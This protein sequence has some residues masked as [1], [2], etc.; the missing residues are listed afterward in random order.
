MLK[1]VESSGS[2]EEAEASLTVTSN[3]SRFDP[4]VCPLVLMLVF[5]AGCLAGKDL[6]QSTQH[7]VVEGGKTK[8]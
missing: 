3:G 2:V 6:G 5:D 7:E 4:M 1:A 8:N